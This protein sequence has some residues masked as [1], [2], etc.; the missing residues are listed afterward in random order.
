MHTNSLIGSTVSLSPLVDQGH[1][2]DVVC[3]TQE[4]TIHQCELYIVNS[5]MSSGQQD[6]ITTVHIC[7]RNDLYCVEWD[8]KL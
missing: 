8:V 6:K 1:Y 3:V 2:E 4:L 5:T 7:L